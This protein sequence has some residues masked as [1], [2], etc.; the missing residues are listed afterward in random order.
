MVNFFAPGGYELATQDRL[1]SLQIDLQNA[2]SEVNTR[3]TGM[4]ASGP[5]FFASLS[6]LQSSYPDGHKG[7]LVTKDNLHWFYWDSNKKQYVDAGKFTDTNINDI[8][9]DEL[10]N[11]VDQSQQYLISSTSTA[12]HDLMYMYDA[13]GDK[14]LDLT[15]KVMIPGFYGGVDGKHNVIL[16]SITIKPYQTGK[17]EVGVARPYGISPIKFKTRE[18]VDITSTDT[19]TI[20]LNQPFRDGDYLT[21]AGPVYYSNPSQGGLNCGVFANVGTDPMTGIHNEET[22]FG[23]SKFNF[24]ITVDIPNTNTTDQPSKLLGKTITYQNKDYYSDSATGEAWQ[25]SQYLLWPALQDRGQINK[26]YY[27]A[28]DNGYIYLAVANSIS[29]DGQYHVHSNVKIP[30]A[31]GPGSADIYLPF[32]AGDHL[33]VGGQLGFVMGNFDSSELENHA[34]PGWATQQYIG[35]LPFGNS[36]QIKFNLYFDMEVEDSSHN[37]LIK[38]NVV[39]PTVFPTQ[40]KK[41]ACFGDSIWSNQVAGL[42]TLVQQDLNAKMIGNFA[43]GWATCQDWFNS[44]NNISPITLKTPQNSDTADN[45]LSNQIR[46]LLQWTTAEGQTIKWQHPVDGEFS[47]NSSVGTGLG[48]TDDIPDIIA[49]SIS[50]NDGKHQQCGNLEDDTDTVFQQHY[51]DLKRNSIASG[52]RW[53]IETLQS[54]YPNSQIYVCTPLQTSGANTWMSYQ[55]NLKKAEIIKKVAAFCSVPVIDQFSESGLN[56]QTVVKG[57]S[58]GV[59]PTGEWKNRIAQFDA[60]HIN[61]YYV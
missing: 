55:N 3:L 44:D 54:A 43:V 27:N 7:I 40:N 42:G 1:N 8:A 58:D 60:H 38:K 2:K 34:S 51:K 47:I 46:R 26:V 5:Y 24:Y 31:K 23:A 13:S 50:T 10:E 59:H 16:S 32:F 15:Q 53:A 17:L 45:V 6:E 57:T 22:A 39:D 12:H 11:K 61:N 30:V 56:N 20:K 37:D 29:N 21:I 41:Y 25:S 19:Q 9:E 49:I 36:Q 33:I 28:P 18:L 4:S 52:L 14:K 35:N 48:H